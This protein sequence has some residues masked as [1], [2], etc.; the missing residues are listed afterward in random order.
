MAPAWMADN[1]GGGEVVVDVTVERDQNV[2]LGMSVNDAEDREIGEWVV[3]EAEQ[4]E[5]F[6]EMVD[7]ARED[8]KRLKGET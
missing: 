5:E 2:F 3:D 8:W 6:F 4:I 1:R 7:R